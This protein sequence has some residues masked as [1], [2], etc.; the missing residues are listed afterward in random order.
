MRR[1][2]VASKVEAVDSQR[3]EDNSVNG[4]SRILR[5]WREMLCDCEVAFEVGK[6][7]CVKQRRKHCDVRQRDDEESAFMGTCFS[8]LLSV[9]AFGRSCRS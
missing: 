9:W 7:G 8:F 5:A 3:I 6:A 2:D 4:S 1:R